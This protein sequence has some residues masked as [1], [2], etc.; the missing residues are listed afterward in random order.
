MMGITQST[1]SP[2]P[3]LAPPCL[4]PAA[5]QAALIFSHGPKARAGC[6]L[7]ETANPAT[8]AAMAVIEIDTSRIVFAPA[9]SA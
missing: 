3:L 9:T 5:S 4:K 2:V 7:K 6:A 1:C 8:S